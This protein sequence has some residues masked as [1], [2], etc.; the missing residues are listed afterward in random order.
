MLSNVDHWEELTDLPVW[1]YYEWKYSADM[2]WQRE[3]YKTMYDQQHFDIV[4]PDTWTD[5]IS[6]ENTE[7]TFSDGTAYFHNKKDDRFYPVPIDT[8]LSG[9]GGGEN[10]SRYIFNESDARERI[11]I[12][13]AERMISNGINCSLDELIRLYG[14]TRFVINGGVVNTFYSNSYHVGMTEMYVMLHEEPELIKYISELVLEQNIEIIRAYA[15]AGGDA[16]YIDDATATS[17]M[18]SRQMYEEFSLPYLIRQVN[19]IHRHNKKA[20]LIYFGG[21][22]DRADLIASIGADILFMECSMKGYINDYADISSKLG[23][24]CLAGNLNPY[25]D[26]EITTDTE[27]A[28]RINAMISAGSLYGRYF[29]GTGSPITPKTPLRRIKTFIDLAHKPV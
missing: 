21:I 3:I 10:E 24:M 9:S 17:D 13:K 1:K 4:Q 27:L 26:L 5:M 22:K 23:G 19:E 18:I 8:H 6:R 25:D 29:T 11:K 7:I 16:I 12:I 15:S 28:E 14:D 20:V 2:N